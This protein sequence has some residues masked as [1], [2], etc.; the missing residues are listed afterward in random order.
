MNIL[1]SKES[2]SNDLEKMRKESKNM[3]DKY[4]DR[5]PCIV[6]RVSG[7]RN[8]VPDIDKKKYIVPSDMQLAQ[9]VSVIRKRIRLNPEQA[10]F[11]FVNNTLPP[12]S[13]SMEQ[14]FKEHK[15][16]NEFLTLHYAGENTF[17]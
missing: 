13:Q 7:S 15:G 16:E 2:V 11:I 8:T 5:I 3:R 1:K 4:P 12:S 6:E 10:L 17:G 14:L 9:F